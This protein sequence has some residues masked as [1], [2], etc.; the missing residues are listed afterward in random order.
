MTVLEL[1]Q[2]PHMD[3]ADLMRQVEAGE[4]VEIQR[5]GAVVARLEP[6]RRGRLT[7]DLF[8]GRRTMQSRPY[9]GNSVVDFRQDERF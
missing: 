5:D 6:V 4:P 8:A 3:L 1:T 7:A 9:P 2:H